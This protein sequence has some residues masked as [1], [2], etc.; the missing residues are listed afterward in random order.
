MYRSEIK[1]N[2]F[3]WEA[4]V[5]GP[6]QI[7]R[8]GANGRQASCAEYTLGTEE[9]RAACLVLGRRAGARAVA[10]RSLLAGRGARP[11]SSQPTG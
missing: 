2:K 6:A 10:G 3:L 4:Q 5:R 9:R 8:D 7:R 11:C 1:P